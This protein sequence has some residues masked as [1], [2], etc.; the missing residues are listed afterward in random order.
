MPSNKKNHQISSNSKS[1]KNTQ[2]STT[3]TTTPTTNIQSTTKRSS[4]PITKYFSIVPLHLLFTFYSI[5]I[6]PSQS[7]LTSTTT[8]SNPTE[9]SINLKNFKWF[10]PLIENPI[11]SLSFINLGLLFVQIWFASSLRNW[12]RN[13]TTIRKNDSSNTDSNSNENKRKK[14][15]GLEVFWKV[16]D[17][18]KNK[19]FDPVA[20]RTIL[21]LIIPIQDALI[22]TILFSF[23]IHL[24]IILIGAPI[25]KN[26]IK[27]YGL[28]L[29]ISILSILPSALVIGWN[30]GREKMTWIR[31][32][33][34]FEPKNELEI[35]LMWPAIGTCI[36]TWLGGIPIPLDWD[37]QWQTW[38]ITCVFGAS[39]G[40]FLGTVI[41]M[42]LVAIRAP[43]TN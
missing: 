35:V 16:F 18:V 22:I 38:P 7:L 4:L 8:H 36:G 11:R 40:H 28:S 25:L 3:T 29:M 12:K 39:I 17:D 34:E 15:L 1:N 23:I 43:L 2:S 41:A 14:K 33:S 24:M 9:K 27:T 19:R 42:V 26:V 5:H 21:E 30:Q 31:I 37:R 32:F 6:L 13:S 20:R 10:E